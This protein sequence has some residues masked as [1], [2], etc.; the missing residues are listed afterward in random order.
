MY[1]IKGYIFYIQI[2]YR[3]LAKDSI[4]VYLSIL[5]IFYEDRFDERSVM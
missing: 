2:L 5:R 1:I 3:K 4:N